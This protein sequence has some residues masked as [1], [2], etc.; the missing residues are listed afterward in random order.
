MKRCLCILLVVT[1]LLTPASS[2]LAIYVPPGSKATPED[3]VYAQK[4]LDGLS[5]DTSRVKTENKLL[6]NLSKM[7]GYEWVVNKDAGKHV[8]I[9]LN[10]EQIYVGP[11]GKTIELE[12]S[13]PEGIGIYLAIMTS[14]TLYGV[15]D[16]TFIYFLD[17][18]IKYVPPEDRLSVATDENGNII[19][20]HD[21]NFNPLDY[22]DPRVI[23]RFDNSYPLFSDFNSSHWAY[24]VI[25]KLTSLGYI[26]G[27]PGGIFKPSGN[28]TRAEYAAIFSHLLEDRYPQGAANNNAK[29]FSD[30]RPDHWSYGVNNK[31]LS[32]ISKN[33][34]LLIFGNSFDPDRKIT[35]EEVVA[36]IHAALKDYIT[37]K[38]DS[39]DA[40]FSDIDRARFSDSISFCVTLGFIKGYPDGTFKPGSSITRAEIAAILAKVA[41]AI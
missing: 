2:A 41:E 11:G 34:A 19:E 13:N 8:G 1:L 9:N 33:D 6:L 37:L 24:N 32:Y 10:W 20:Y 40:V 27:Y 36:I 29:L 30:L 15:A 35:R 12:I 31:M 21:I 3:I 14:I 17:T 26:K 38:F 7:E 5:W 23:N 4:A 28:I 18:G 16:E 22:Y 25:Y 39:E